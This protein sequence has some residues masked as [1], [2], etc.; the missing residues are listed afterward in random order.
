[1]VYCYFYVSPTG[2]PGPFDS[3]SE[4]CGGGKKMR[5]NGDILPCNTQP[6]NLREYTSSK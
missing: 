5:S 2:N 6:C 4:G 1:M 3:C